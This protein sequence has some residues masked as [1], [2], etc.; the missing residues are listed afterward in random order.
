MTHSAVPMG[1]WHTVE[2]TPDFRGGRCLW[3]H[4]NDLLR[5]V[6]SALECRECEPWHQTT[7]FFLRCPMSTISSTWAFQNPCW[8]CSMCTFETPCAMSGHISQ[9]F[10]CGYVKYILESLFLVYSHVVSYSHESYSML[11][12]RN[13]S[14][15]VLYH[16]VSLFPDWSPH[17][18]V[19]VAGV[20][21]N[22]YH[23]LYCSGPIPWSFWMPNV[24]LLSNLWACLNLTKGDSMASHH[25][26][27]EQMAIHWG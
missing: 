13:R 10:A 11:K 20:F 25:F 12:K 15:T 18:L 2:C 16:S 6:H 23:T 4:F 1:V 26:A 7:P 14:T 5:L 3:D 21:S 8:R 17:D 19:I 22:I 24:F 9:Y 27:P